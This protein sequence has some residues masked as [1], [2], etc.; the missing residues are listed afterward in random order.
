MERIHSTGELPLFRTLWTFIGQS[1]AD[2]LGQRVQD[3]V[4][5][6]QFRDNR[7][8]DLTMDEVADRRRLVPA[9]ARPD[10]GRAA[11]RATPPG[12]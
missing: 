10:F 2:V 12:Q 5:G 4:Q 1:L 11:T 3:A 9:A 6:E 8:A 7:P